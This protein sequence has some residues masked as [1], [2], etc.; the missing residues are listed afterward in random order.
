MDKIISLK[1][2]CCGTEELD[3]SQLYCS[4]NI[5]KIKAPVNVFMTE[6]KKFGPIL[7]NTGFSP[8]LKINRLNYL[9]FS[10]GRSISFS[11]A[12]TITKLLSDDGMDP[13]CVRKVLLTDCLPESCGSLCMLPR[14]EL[15]SS[16]GVLSQLKSGSVMIPNLVP[17]DDIPCRVPGI[18]NGDTFLKGYFRFIFDVFGDG[19]VLAVETSGN[20]EKMCLFYLTEHNILFAGNASSDECA[21]LDKLEPTRKLLHKQYSK[22][23]YISLLEKLRDMKQRDRQLRIFFTHSREADISL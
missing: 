12:D 15:I 7:I 8:L 11:S 14:Y 2:Y 23:E 9:R 13:L 18:Y 17:D 21:V 20:S 4:C 6:H 22:K 3:L 19:S 1:K 5:G 10:T 16:P